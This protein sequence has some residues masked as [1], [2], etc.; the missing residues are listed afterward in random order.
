MK[1]SIAI[2]MLTLTA[3]VGASSAMARDGGGSGSNL[4]MEPFT[5]DVNKATVR[6]QQSMYYKLAKV[7][8]DAKAK[9]AE[10][11]K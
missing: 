7:Q 8:A 6:E 5:G 2:A 11:S 9:K 3:I 4:R 10:V 1:K